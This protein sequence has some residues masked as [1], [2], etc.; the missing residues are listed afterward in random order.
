VCTDDKTCTLRVDLERHGKPTASR[1]VRYE[2]ALAGKKD[3]VATIQK[4]AAK[5]ASKGAPPDAPT[6][7]LAVKE[8]APGTV[9]VRSDID[10]ALELD[11]AM[12]ANSAFAACA[13]KKKSKSDARGYWAEWKLNA[14]GTAMEVFVKPFGGV[15]PADDAAA[16]CLRDAL[17]K[18]QMACPRDGQIVKVKTAI[19]L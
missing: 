19:C 14:K 5:L 1:W 11:A 7:G 16:K 12:E 13:P 4:A 9:T 10:G 8:L 6:K 17:Q 15:D 3:Q 18:M 2:S